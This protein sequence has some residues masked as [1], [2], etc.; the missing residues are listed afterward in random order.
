MLFTCSILASQPATIE[1]LKRSECLK[2]PEKDF[3]MAALPCLKRPECLKRTLDVRRRWR[4]SEKV[5]V[6][7]ATR[8]PEKGFEDV[9]RM[10]EQAFGYLNI[11]C[12][13]F[14]M[15]VH[16]HISDILKK[17]NRLASAV[18]V[19]LSPASTSHFRIHDFNKT[20]ILQK[21]SPALVL[22]H[23]ADTP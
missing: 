11:R 1:C 14:C 18:S 2:R 19:I 21:H 15:L 5:F 12:L 6:W 13:P 8:M 22:Q 23:N 3:F 9:I 10:P 17:K 4:M 16:K 7:T 20:Q